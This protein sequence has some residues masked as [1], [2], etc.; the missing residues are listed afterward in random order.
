MPGHDAEAA[1]RPAPRHVRLD[2]RGTWDRGMWDRYLSTAAA[3]E[4]D[5][6]P[7]MLRLHAEI[8]RLERISLLPAAPE[9]RAA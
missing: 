7:Q 4:P 6:M 5:Y 3:L 9:A 1:A 8:E 2:D